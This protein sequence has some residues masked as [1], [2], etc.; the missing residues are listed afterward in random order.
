MKRK[1][2]VLLLVSVMV[3]SLVACTAKTNT[4]TP[5]GQPAAPGSSGT[6]GGTSPSPGVSPGA[7]PGVSP[8]VSPANPAPSPGAPAKPVE[9]TVINNI[10][11]N[12]LCPLTEDAAHNYAITYHIYDR[13]VNFD[14][15]TN[16][17]LPNIAKSWKKVDDVTWTFEIDLSFKFSNGDQLTMDDVV[18]SFE[19]LKAVPKQ[20]DAA[21][22]VESVSYSGTTLTFK[23]SG[24]SITIPSRV[25]S[26]VVI[27]NKKH[28]E[29]GGDEAIFLKPIGTGP[30]KVTEFTPGA[31]ATIELWDG[32]PFERPKIDKINY[33]A[34]MENAARYVALET[35]AATFVGYLSAFEYNLAKENKSI[36]AVNV[37]SRRG[38]GIMFNCQKAP[39][40]NVNVRRALVYALDRDGFC[41]LQGGGRTPIKSM[42]FYGYPYYVESA[43]T[44]GYDPAKA[45]AM[46]AEAGFN[47]ANPL[48]IELICVEPEAGIEMYTSALAD[49]GVELNVTILEHSVYL[50]REGAGEFD[51]AYVAQTNRAYHPISDVDRFDSKLIGSRDISRYHNDRVQEIIGQLR[52]TTDEQKRVAL[53]KEF[54]DILGQEVPMV[55]VFL[56]PL[57]FAMDKR[58]TG[59]EIS[60]IQIVNFRKATFTG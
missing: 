17:W 52:L 51:M 3:F 33:K 16:E 4:E 10:I 48:K 49:I 14:L 50:K 9:I 11:P 37:P 23:A 39:F 15:N 25:V 7:S 27:L 41:K 28:V 46:L 45:K 34:I 18:F 22:M 1:L 20:A 13:L 57:F 19:R 6:Q 42:V 24:P 32:Y 5:A 30:Y 31:S 44:P 40:D 47:A 54:V 8:G 21:G 60:P 59:V 38:F 56:S 12:G 43:N 26:A 55:G 53:I 2:I 36:E 29:A 58:L 35:G